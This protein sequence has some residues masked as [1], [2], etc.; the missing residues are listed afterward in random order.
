MLLLVVPCWPIL[1]TDSGRSAKLSILQRLLV[2]FKMPP[3]ARR[4]CRNAERPDM[5]LVNATSRSDPELAASPSS[6]TPPSAVV[7]NAYAWSRRIDGPWRW[8]TRDD[9]I[10]RI[11]ENGSPD[12]CRLSDEPLAELVKSNDGRQVWRIQLE[13]ALVF[14]KLYLPPRGWVRLRHWLIASDA[15]RERRVAEYAC[16]HGI[17]TVRPIASADA[18]E[19]GNAPSGLLVTE[20]IPGAVPLNEFWSRLDLGARTTRAA[21]NTVIGRVARLIAHAHQCGFEHTDLHAGN[22]LLSGTESDACQAHF[23]DLHN[24]RIG[25]PVS[26]VAVIRNLAQFHQWFRLHSPLTDRLRFLERYLQWRDA[27]EPTGAYGR[28]LGLRADE[29]LAALE[30]AARRHANALYAQRDR[31]ATRPGRYFTR[32]RLSHGWRGYAYLACKHPVD[33]SPASQATLTPRQWKDWLCHPRRL[34]GPEQIGCVIKKSPS[35]MVFRSRLQAEA[36]SLEVVGK[37]SR[38]RHLGKRIQNL[39]RPSRAMRTWRL[40]NALLN[41]QV[42][43]ARPL[44][45][46]ERKRFGLV[47]DSLLLTECIEHAHDLDVLLSLPLRERT[48]AEQYRLKSGVS[49]ALARVFRLLFARGFIHR[50]FKASNVIVQWDPAGDE[51]PR[52]LLVDLDGLRKCG[53]PQRRHWIRALAR[54]GASLEHCRRVTRTDRLRFLKQVLVQ[55]GRPEP[56]WKP[57]WR[58]IARRARRRDPK[59][60]RFDRMMAK[61]SEI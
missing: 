33:G 27:F 6:P 11:H 22:V 41:R 52:V 2:S 39:F 45:V 37:R 13:D 20:G 12:W 15:E 32:L 59:S 57:A 38:P 14:V 47:L 5:S 1:I 16:R 19:P 3:P 61:L 31:R 23:V 44:A 35:A 30:V 34:I 53:K 18:T 49:A 28:R 54:L 42:P 43:T 36:A 50:D 58:D 60:P 56:Q 48:A 21:K 55:P 17:N 46:V 9:W 51:P 8:T 24:I 4:S 10:H 40:A 26:D 29:M 7:R 25:R